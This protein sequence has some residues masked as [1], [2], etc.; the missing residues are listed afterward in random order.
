MRAVMKFGG[1]ILTDAGSLERLAAI[2]QSRAKRSNVLVV[3][4][5]NGVTDR[6]IAFLDGG[7]DDEGSVERF[8]DETASRHEIML[9]GI[10]ADAAFADS[11]RKLGRLLYGICYTQEVSE[12][13]RNLALSFGERLAAIMVARKLAASGIKARELF[14]EQAGIV[15]A[16]GLASGACRFAETR[17]NIGTITGLL[18]QGI[19]PVITGFYGIDANGD[20]VLFGRGGTDYSAGIM[21]KVLDADLLEVWKDVPGFLSADPKLIPQA[22]KL[23]EISF[24]EAEEL[25]YFG[26]KILHPRTID[27][28]RG[29]KVTAHICNF[30]DPDARGTRIVAKRQRRNR[31]SSV[32]CKDGICVISVASGAMV[33]VPGVLGRLFGTLAESGIVVDAVSTSQVAIAFT[34]DRHDLPN[35]LQVLGQLQGSIIESVQVFENAALIGIVGE[36]F[37]ANDGMAARILSSVAQAGVRPLMILDPASNNSISLVTKSADAQKAA[38]AIYSSLGLGDAA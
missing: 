14:A 12:R 8:I 34:I 36:E 26:A 4:A 37:M 33:G 2:V 31:V 28:I 19:V 32:S 23:D 18:N 38:R 17:Q 35:A 20:V 29:T 16:A 9:A 30:F 5:V 25:G 22:R 3:S 27:C 21:A 10:T 6:L 13:I 1:G 15:A 7:V 24:S 11:I